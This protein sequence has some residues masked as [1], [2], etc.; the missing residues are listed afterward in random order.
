MG[1]PLREPDVEVLPWTLSA[2]RL[3]VRWYLVVLLLVCAAAGL[4][5]PLYAATEPAIAL[6]IFALVPLFGLYTLR[7]RNL[8]MSAQAVEIA[9]SE[10]A[11]TLR[12]GPEVPRSQLVR[13][14]YSQAGD[15]YWLKLERRAFLRPLWFRVGL[16]DDARRM[17]DALGLASTFRVKV[18]SRAQGTGAWSFGA[19]GLVIPFVAWLAATPFL[20]NPTRLPFAL[21]CAGAVTLVC[22]II[23]FTPTRVEIDERGVTLTWLWTRRTVPFARI[24]SVRARRVALGNGNYVHSVELSTGLGDVT[25]LAVGHNA[26]GGAERASSLQFRLEDGLKAYQRSASPAQT[27]ESLARD[28]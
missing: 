16:R 3:R 2:E 5:S 12:P 7:V 22:W 4:F 6:T 28:D 1:A 24:A 10:R 23:A 17:L 20:D 9:I 21:A 8:G 14:S 11:L 26:F 18:G 19:V 25:R 13:G 15:G 27:L